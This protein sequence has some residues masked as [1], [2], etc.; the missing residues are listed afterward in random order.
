MTRSA[1]TMALTMTL[2][3]CTADSPAAAEATPGPS[4]AA[5]ATATAAAAAS[6]PAAPARVEGG[7]TVDGATVAL[8]DGAAWPME[9]DGDEPGKR[10][11]NLSFSSLPLNLVKLWRRPLDQ[12]G[13]ELMSQLSGKPGAAT[14]ELDVIQLPAITAEDVEA[15]TED[16]DY[17]DMRDAS[18]TVHG[19]TLWI[20]PGT[21]M[22][23]SGTRIGTLGL[24]A[25]PGARI[26]GSFVMTE[27]EDYMPCTV[28]F[29]LP[30][31]GDP[32]S[33][34][35]GAALPPG[36]GDAGKALIAL[37]AALHAADADAV[38]AESQPET[39]A[40]RREMLEKAPDLLAMEMV[41]MA[42]SL[43]ADARVTGGAIEGDEA[44]LDVAGTTGALGAAVKEK[45]AQ[46][47]REFGDEL[48]TGEAGTPFRAQVV[49]QRAD[50]R[51]RME[52]IQQP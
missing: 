43:P 9:T 6:S 17:V 7:C 4:P 18:D 20:A 21:S 47:F 45:Y 19:M 30:I 42:I 23:T 46:V 51:W 35:Q 25:P 52:S 37:V 50:G 48:D 5:A 8:T 13:S 41:W 14:L 38:I 12:R 15:L 33:A 22:S 26:A 3:A 32:A 2:I 49:M 27:D 28:R 31:L 10:R 36:G 39:A 1:L 24:D 11:W 44:L 16:D 40:E 34:P 29:D